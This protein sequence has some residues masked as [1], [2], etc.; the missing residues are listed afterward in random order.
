[1]T[2]IISL[3]FAISGSI[4][5]GLALRVIFK[6]IDPAKVSGYRK[7]KGGWWEAELNQCDSGLVMVPQQPVNT[8]SNLAYL[9]VALFLMFFINTL[10]VYILSLTL[11]YL[12]VGSALYH[13]TS[14]RWAGSLDVSAMYAVF[15]VLAVFAASKFTMLEDSLVALIMFVVAGLSA[16]FLRYKF[17]G[18]MAIKIG[19]FL[20]LTYSLAVWNMLKSNN[21]ESKGYLIVSFVL[22]VVA[23]LVWNLDKWRFFPFKRWGHG[24]W[25]IISAVAIS[26][27]FYAMHLM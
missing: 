3:V 8:Y 20:I 17:R 22:F 19:I 4:V 9:A 27:L 15:S 1:M 25:H 10:T 6:G 12:C 5:V 18:S 14:T 2:L 11:M 16:Y 26:I 23:F 21:L 24:F 13:A 7:C